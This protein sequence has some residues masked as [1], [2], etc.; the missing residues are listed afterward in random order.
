MDFEQS[1]SSVR[2]DRVVIPVVK[3]DDVSWDSYVMHSSWTALAIGHRE[4][5]R[6]WDGLEYLA[7]FYYYNPG[8]SSTFEETW[9]MYVSEGMMDGT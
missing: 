7:D 1:L 5:L 2:R 4:P 3:D 9:W 8:C 6:T